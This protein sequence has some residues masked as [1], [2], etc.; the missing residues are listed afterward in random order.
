MRTSAS[1]SN[2]T[3]KEQ[4]RHPNC[5]RIGLKRAPRNPW[6]VSFSFGRGKIRTTVRNISK[7]HASSVP[8]PDEKWIVVIVFVHNDLGVF[9]DNSL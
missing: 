2:S 6:T 8:V 9:R 1:G 4:P 5:A 3:V 7:I